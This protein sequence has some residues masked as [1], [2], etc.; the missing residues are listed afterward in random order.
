MSTKIELSCSYYIRYF[1]KV[2]FLL[3]LINVKWL[4]EARYASTTA[5]NYTHSETYPFEAIVKR[6]TIL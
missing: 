1:I 4:H 6:A 5:E 2:K 3:C